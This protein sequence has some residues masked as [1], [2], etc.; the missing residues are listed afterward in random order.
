M[1]A[2]NGI[3]KFFESPFFRFIL[4][5][6]RVFLVVLW[7]SVA[8]WTYR[9]AKSR[10]GMA[11]YWS[12]VALLFPVFG[13]LIYLVVRPQERVADAQE[14]DLEIKAK[15][16]ALARSGIVCPACM[17]PVESDFLICPYCLKKLKKACPECDHALK[18]N[19][20]ICPYC[21]TS[22]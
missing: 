15:E 14:R 13:W 4:V 6:G 20:T 18:L 7:I 2:I 21:Q 5:L 11:G 3:I 17:R 8:Y 19:W 10:G 22:Q 16:S 1:D 9:D 12:I